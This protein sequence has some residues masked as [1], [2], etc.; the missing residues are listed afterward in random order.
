MVL[1]AGYRPITL[2]CDYLLVTRG[3]PT[4]PK[5]LTAAAVGKFRP[6]GNKAREI[7]DGGS[8]SLRLC[9]H[10]SGAKS[11]IMRFR[12]PSGMTAKLTLGPVDLSGTENPS[13]PVLGM[14]LT[15]AAARR[16]AA[17]VHRRR[18]MGRDVIADYKAERER[19]RTDLKNQAQNTFGHAVREFFTDY[20]TKWHTRPRRFRADARQLGLAWPAGS[21]P[22]TTEPMI[23]KGGLADV[24]ADKP[25]VDIDGHDIHTIVDEARKHGVPGLVRRNGG[26]SESRGRKM[27]AALS[28]VFRWLVRHRR[29]AANPCAD[30]WRPGA[31]PAR[32][33]V[34]ND[35]EIKLLWKACDSISVPFAAALK[36]M[37]LTGA[38]ENEVAGMQRNELSADGHWTLPAERSKNHRA[39]SL[40]LPSLA[41]AIIA[42]VP[43]VEPGSFVFTHNG[44]SKISGWS[45]MKRRLDQKMPS[46]PAWRIHDLRRTCASGM[47][48]LG[49]RVDIIE[50]ALNHVSGSF[51]GIVGVY[52]RDPLSE[53]VAAAL[54]RWSQHVVGLVE[55]APDKVTPM[56]RAVP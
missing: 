32:D 34:L 33:R 17:E 16:L 35:A 37:L 25:V 28:V 18:A 47:Q 27:H 29:V 39:H 40:V 43:R 9:I 53:E 11:W 14:P 22:T 56:R 21:D 2:C 55:G 51:G 10:S 23:L 44:R 24:W 50:R 49:V 45:K 4:M 26:T 8:P 19:K 15:L 42:S 7:P 12:R 36:I 31:P 5:V 30:V 20:K 6:A 3:D 13:D 48:R 46:V 54:L 38:R 52:Q 41:L 1:N